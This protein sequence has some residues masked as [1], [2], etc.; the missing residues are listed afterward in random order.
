M[1]VIPLIATTVVTLELLISIGLFVP[2]LQR[3]S[4]QSMTLLCCT[5]ISYSAWRW[6][7]NIQAPCHCFGILFTLQP[8]QAILFN[9]LLLALALQLMPEKVVVAPFSRAILKGGGIKA[10]MK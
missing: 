2:S 1:N 9:L 5:F 10:E 3:A 8:Y 6:V 7:Q 4:L